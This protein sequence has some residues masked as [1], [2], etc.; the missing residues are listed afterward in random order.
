[1]AR[2]LPEHP[3]CSVSPMVARVHRLVQALPERFFAWSPVVREGSDLPDF[4]VVEE[5]T[6]R[7]VHL[8]VSDA[9]EDQARGPGLFEA[10][11]A[12][13]PPSETESARVER[14][15][16]R[17]GEDA[18]AGAVL[19]PDIPADMLDK[20]IGGWPRAG[21][22]ICRPAAFTDWIDAQ[23]GQALDPERS[24]TIRSLFC[25]ETVLHKR[26]AMRRNPS[27][28]DVPRFLT[29]K[30]EEILKTD[31]DPGA[32]GRQAAG[33][34]G[35]LVV[36]G[37][38]GSGKTLILLHR[39]LLLSKLRR[40]SRILVLTCNK[41]L[42]V[43]LRRRFQELSGRSASVE[44]LTFHGFCLKRW[45]GEDRPRVLQ[46]SLRRSLLDES[47]A[48]LR[49]PLLMRRHL[50]EELAWIFDNGFQDEDTY[51]KSP[52]RG[53]GFRMDAEL[54]AGMWTAANRFRTECAKEK[55]ADWNLL[56]LLF[57]ESAQGKELAGYD[58]ILVDEAQFFAPVWFD[59]LRAFLA[60]RGH[61]F[62]SADPTQGFL[63]KGTSWKSVGL[64]VHGR[65]R[66][67]ERSHRSTRAIMELAW[68]VWST[69]AEATDSDIVVPRMEGMGDG[70]APTWYRFPDVRSEFAWI[71]DQVAGFLDGGG[72]PRDIL[73][74]HDDWNGAAEL[75]ER[76]E[77]RIGA[78]RI[79]DARDGSK[80]QALRVC[81]LN[82]ATGLESP[83]VFLSGTQRIFE[84][85]GSPELDE[86]ARSQARDEATRK[87]YMALTRAGWRLV[88]TST[89]PL[90]PEI[91]QCFGANPPTGG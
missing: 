31:L 18:G 34:F 3:S 54:R 67:L 35:L 42:Q 28:P 86:E 81:Q 2:L 33:D 72:A 6:G 20:N 51:A 4:W 49:R 85:E 13:R 89:G 36:Q 55:A 16:D 40:E 48:T 19:F 14:V 46:A 22:E 75:R 30:Q 39:A 37:V 80:P 21:R 61:L 12:W 76:L 47:L 84:R 68:R 43:E 77:S 62:L 29:W 63:R 27:E 57:R 44:I 25:P 1:M 66:R 83:V 17:L 10:A 71:E 53:R 9:T 69:R 65:S 82:A 52:R 70:P 38:A 56:P 74:L 15:K 41:P 11:E 24:R 26:H 90:P 5:K 88:V 64:S 78:D 8:V 60:P 45:P 58:A 91:V 79:A 50:E 59:C 32:D 73:V 87:I 7:C 23:L